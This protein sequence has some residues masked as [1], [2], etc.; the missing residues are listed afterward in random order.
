[1]SLATTFLWTAGSTLAKIAIG[2]VVIKL[3]AV[4]FGPGGVVGL[5]RNYRQLIYHDGGNNSS[6]GARC[7]HHDA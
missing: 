1:M 2:L 7:L 3:L 6:D 4:A 5:A